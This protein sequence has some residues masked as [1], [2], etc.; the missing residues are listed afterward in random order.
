MP[1]KKQMEACFKGR[2][3]QIEIKVKRGNER[4]RKDRSEGRI[5]KMRMA[6][7]SYLLLQYVKTE[8]NKSYRDD[9]STAN[10][11]NMEETIAFENVLI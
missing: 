8:N 4:K 11:L 2:K 9:D 3:H 5:G 10:K 7:V 1:Y 6:D